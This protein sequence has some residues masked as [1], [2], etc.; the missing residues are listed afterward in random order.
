MDVMVR[1][2]FSYCTSVVNRVTILGILVSVFILGCDRAASNEDVEARLA[3]SGSATEVRAV[4]VRYGSFD[5]LVQTTGKIRPSLEASVQV[6]QA[7]M[8]KRVY[9]SNGDFVLQ[10]GLIA[11]LELD[12]LILNL[13]KAEAALAE[14]QVVFDDLV[15]GFDAV[16]DS[17]KRASIM[18]NLGYSSGLVSAQLAVKQAQLE[19]IHSRVTSPIAGVVTTLLLKEN[20]LAPI[21]KAV[22][23]VYAPQ[24]LE[25][26][27]FVSEFDVDLIRKG[28]LVEIRLAG[29]RSLRGQVKT[30]DPR[31]QEATNQVKVN[32]LLA[33]GSELYPQAWLTRQSQ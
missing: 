14:K 22:A 32:I 19:L 7:G 21:D 5:Y 18:R 16:T 8:V 27:C 15:M 25:V 11:E 31:V 17:A 33:E 10:G 28:Y 30:I 3:P 23:Y 24:G 2:V 1:F 9:V 29:G 20:N 13:A 4:P 12:Q 26:E 6:R